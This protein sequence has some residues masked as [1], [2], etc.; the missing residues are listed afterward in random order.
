MRPIPLNEISISA[1]TTEATMLIGA[2]IVFVAMW[3]LYKLY[4]PR[5]WLFPMLSIGLFFLG[6]LVDVLDEFYRMPVCA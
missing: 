5:E 3:R 6:M 4:G 1:L 2:L